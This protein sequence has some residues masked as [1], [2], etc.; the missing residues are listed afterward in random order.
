MSLA[1]LIFDDPSVDGPSVDASSVDAS[2]VFVEPPA[3]SGSITSETIFDVIATFAKN[4]LHHAEASLP[5]YATAS[6]PR[7]TTGVSE[8]DPH[9]K[10]PHEPGAKLDAGK[11]RMHLVIGGFPRALRAVGE[12]ATFGAAKYT[13]G[14]WQHVPD[15]LNR[16]ADAQHRHELAAA[17]DEMRDADSGLLHLA[18]MA[19]NALARLELLLRL[20]NRSE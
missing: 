1:P 6:D 19:W 18:H 7:T 14:G 16:Y 9:N 11:V 8:L 4:A 12:V 2:S 10:T 15:A 13:S 3:S 5:Q 20:E 17:R